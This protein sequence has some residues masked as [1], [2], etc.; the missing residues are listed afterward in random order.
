MESIKSLKEIILK[1]RSCHVFAMCAL[2][3]AACAP[4]G[5]K[6]TVAVTSVTL[7]PTAAIALGASKTLIASVAPSDASDKGITWT[8]DAPSVASVDGSG[9]VTGASV[10]SA[11][12]SAASAADPSKKASCTVTVKDA[13][14][15]ILNV[16]GGTLVP[17]FDA[18]V[19]SYTM[20]VNSTVASLNVAGTVSI[21]GATL[22][23]SHAQPLTLDFGNTTITV[24]V[25]LDDGITTKDYQISVT[26]DYVVYEAGSYMS[27]PGTSAPCY[28]IGAEQHTLPVATS[29]GDAKSIFVSGTTIYVGGETAAGACYWE[30][31]TRTN[32]AGTG[33]TSVNSIV[34]SGG[35][36]Y[37][38]GYYDSRIP[39]YWMGATRQPDLPT[40]SSASG[41][42]YSICV[43]G[44]AVNVGGYVFDGTAGYYRPCYWSGSS[45]SSMAR[46][47]LLTP[48]NG[49]SVVLAIAVSG[50]AV[51]SAGYFTNGTTETPCYWIGTEC[52]P[53]PAGTN[54]GRAKSISVSGGLVYT[55]GYYI[56][57]VDDYFSLNIP[58]FWT[59]STRTDLQ[60]TGYMG[61]M[62]NSIQVSNGRFFFGGSSN[63]LPCYWNGRNKTVLSTDV[64][65]ACNAVFAQ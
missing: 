13:N 37:S 53:L 27:T 40:L 30:N 58:C 46:T 35:T 34:Y 44:S 32:L 25:A 4:L 9:R 63:S 51:Y 17:A 56:T 1:N 31:G 28:W 12:I 29:S 43:N 59:G 50:G 64:N 41:Q 10:G 52:Y 22:S 7:Q 54:G 15:T 65:A 18:S 38:A 62:I 5:A 23:Y 6:K 48:T 45:G 55:G 26:K 39:C 60:T 11:T 14:L 8:S 36:I 3:L 16:T 24:T 61:D 47:D 33:V 2:F 21:P 42:A 57:G 19:S 20:S 49:D